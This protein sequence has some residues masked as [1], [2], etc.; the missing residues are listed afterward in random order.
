M[1]QA[2][3]EG[4]GAENGAAHEFFARRKKWG[5]NPLTACGKYAIL[6]ELKQTTEMIE[7]IEKPLLPKHG[8]WTDRECG[9]ASVDRSDEKTPGKRA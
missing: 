3:K 5:E 9:M 8:K 1:Q 2:E 7:V 4:G 6:P